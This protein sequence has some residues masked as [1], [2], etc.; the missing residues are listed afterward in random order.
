MSPTSSTTNDVKD[1]S[2]S[3]L[4]SSSQ[5]ISKVTK[6]NADVV[7]SSTQEQKSAAQVSPNESTNVDSTEELANNNASGLSKEQQNQQ[8]QPETSTNDLNSSGK[9]KQDT[10]D[11]SSILIS[12][13]RNYSTGPPENTAP[14]TKSSNSSSPTASSKPDSELNDSFT[15]AAADTQS[16]HS[17]EDSASCETKSTVKNSDSKYK[18]VASAASAKQMPKQTKSSNDDS[19]QQTTQPSTSNDNNGS[20][21]ATAES[22]PLGSSTKQESSGEEI[23]SNRTKEQALF[24]RESRPSPIGLQDESSRQN[25]RNMRS[26]SGLNTHHQHYHHNSHYHH[27]NNYQNQNLQQS[28]NNHDYY[29]SESALSKTNLY[30]RGLDP[31]TTDQDL[32]M[33]CSRFGPI[34]STKAILD[35]PSNKCKGYGFV[36]FDLPTSAENAVAK[37]QKQGIL[38]HMA[39]QQEADPT[40][41]YIA[42]LPLQMTDIELANLL[43]PFGTVV[44]TRILVHVLTKKSRGVGFARMETK[45]QCE[46]IIVQLNQK[47]VKGSQEPLLVKFADGAGKK[48]NNHNH[49]YQNKQAFSGYMSEPTWRSHAQ[50]NNDPASSQQHH[51]SGT[52]G[53]PPNNRNFQHN[54]YEHNS[55]QG[56]QM[57]THNNG[58][59]K[60]QQQSLHYHPQ[61]PGVHHQMPPNSLHLGHPRQQQSDQQPLSQQQQGQQHQ[62]HQTPQQPQPPV[63]QSPHQQ[64]QQQQHHHHHHHPNHSQAAH[65]N[66]ATGAYP[67]TAGYPMSSPMSAGDTSQQW[68]HP[69]PQAGQPYVL[70]PQLLPTSLHYM[71]LANQMQGMHLNAPVG[72]YLSPHHWSVWPNV[73]AKHSTAPLN[74][75]HVQPPP[76]PPPS[77]ST[78]IN[79]NYTETD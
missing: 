50:H 42:N 69:H 57:M 16:A 22:D 25:K 30:I 73:N 59:M 58:I 65:R 33:M 63:H 76:Q 66:Q 12:G 61:H 68:M 31:D 72:G 43:S 8:E 3:N 35:K 78:V 56:Q 29:N 41:L 39:K 11:R 64:P 77:S 18:I 37:L 62:P 47:H 1:V 40:N 34:V 23:T 26:Q 15:I 51:S 67:P 24:G 19:A 48:K 38:V 5:L 28:Q 70:Q 9:H 14:A 7:V 60:H 20:Q 17:N 52:H 21:L 36:D 54:T 75:N 53:N 55:R 49:S 46:E 27:Q 4:P 74:S 32:Y 44:S 2:S 6:P 71:N 45:E 10:C 13:N 79:G